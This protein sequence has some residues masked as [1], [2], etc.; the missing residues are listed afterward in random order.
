VCRKALVVVVDLEKQA[1]T[2][3]LQRPKV[4]LAI[5]I[6]VLVKAVEASNV[7]TTNDYFDPSSGTA[8]VTR[9]PSGS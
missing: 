5:G 6:V 7:A 8:T 2:V 4:V 1:L 9:R 3:D